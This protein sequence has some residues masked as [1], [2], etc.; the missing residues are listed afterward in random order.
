MLYNK[1]V[2]YP[3]NFE[4]AKE[5][6]KELNVVDLPGALGSTDATHVTTWECEYNLRNTH[7]GGKLMSTT[8][9]YN[10]TM[11]GE[12]FFILQEG[13]QEDGMTKLWSYLI[14]L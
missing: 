13:G 4:E 11:I 9:S 1:Y 14:H 10:I 5:H 3:K 7:L 6:M 8:C 2:V 12:G